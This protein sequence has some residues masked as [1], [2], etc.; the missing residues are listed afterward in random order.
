MLTAPSTA[1]RDPFA[2]VTVPTRYAPG[3]QRTPYPY[4][5]RNIWHAVIHY[6]STRRGESYWHTVQ[7]YP[8]ASADSTD[9]DMPLQQHGI[10]AGVRVVTGRAVPYPHDT[11]PATLWV[12]PTVPFPEDGAYQVHVDDQQQLMAAWCEAHAIAAALNN[13]TVA[14]LGLQPQDL[15]I[16]L[17]AARGQLVG[18]YPEV[19]RDFGYVPVGGGDVRTVEKW[20]VKQLRSG[21]RRMIEPLAR[22]EFEPRNETRYTLSRCGTAAVAKIRAQY[23]GPARCRVCGCTQERACPDRC[24]WAEPD[25]CSACPQ[26]V[27]R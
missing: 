6:P 27:A 18:D 4:T 10:R 15:E 14:K 20:R 1:Q 8:A 7:P 26:E 19:W 13:G 17:A 11:D 16:L 3:Y 5:D 2:G 21:D 23:D 9:G 12:T 22:C 25:R 24:S